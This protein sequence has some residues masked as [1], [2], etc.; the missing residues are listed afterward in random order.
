MKILGSFV[1]FLSSFVTILFND[2]ADDKV[3]FKIIASFIL[4]NTQ[5]ELS[6][7][8]FEQTRT[9]FLGHSEINF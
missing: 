1:A 5:I 2:L 3:R 6:F 9:S 8:H 4:F 7:C